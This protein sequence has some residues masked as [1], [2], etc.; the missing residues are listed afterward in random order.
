MF[1]SPITCYNSPIGKL[2]IVSNQRAIVSLRFVDDDTL[3]EFLTK[4]SPI[5]AKCL[6]QL[7]EYFRGE[8]K[9]FTVSISYKG[10]PFQKTVWKELTN[11]PFGQTCTYKDIAIKLGNC[12]A[13]RIIGRVNSNNP[14][15]IIVPCHRVIGVNNKL[16]GYTGGIWRKKWLLDHEKQYHESS[17][18]SLP[19]F[20]Q[21]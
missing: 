8:R 13:S 7:D 15:M 1:N 9:T 14:I 12:N 20:F 2:K 5:L 4:W 6:N 16:R 21:N 17:L 11:I 19:K 18:S 3:E 10:T